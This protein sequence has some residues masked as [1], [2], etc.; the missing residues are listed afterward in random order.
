MA[1]GQISG[2]TSGDVDIVVWRDSNRVAM[3]STYHGVAVHKEDD[4]IKPIVV[5]DYNVCMGGVDR[6]D[7]M[8]ST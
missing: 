4:K 7:R 2:C 1:V 8:L 5:Q 6:K 3:I